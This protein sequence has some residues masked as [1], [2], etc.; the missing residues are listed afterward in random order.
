M[1]EGKN[2]TKKKNIIDLIKLVL[3]WT[4]YFMVLIA[5]G[6]YV[7]VEA[8][9]INLPKSFEACSMFSMA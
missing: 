2:N 5:P 8:G 1:G 9:N 6:I 3:K 4:V 7:M